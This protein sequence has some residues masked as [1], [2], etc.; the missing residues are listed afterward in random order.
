[1]TRRN[2][3]LLLIIAN[4]VTLCVLG[5]Y[6]GNAAAQRPAGAEN[7]FGNSVEQRIEMVTQ[8]KE[9][10]DLLKEQNAFLRSGKLQVIVTLPEKP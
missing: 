9:I 4:V 6:Q 8:L 2:A 1:M 7:M 10:K 5:F 3:W